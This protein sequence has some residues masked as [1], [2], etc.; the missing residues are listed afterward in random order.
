M[1]ASH[2]ARPAAISRGRL[3]VIRSDAADPGLVTTTGYQVHLDLTV[4]E[5]RHDQMMIAKVAGAG[6]R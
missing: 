2:R 5:R 3:V 6:N 1:T 4:A